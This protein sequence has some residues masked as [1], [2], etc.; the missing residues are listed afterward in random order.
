MG[1]ERGPLSLVSTIEELLEKNKYR[2]RS[3]NPRIRL[4][5]YVTLTT[6]HPLSKK[7]LTNFAD[8]RRS[9]CRYCSLVDPSHGVFLAKFHKPSDSV[10]HNRENPLDNTKLV[11]M[12]ERA[13]PTSLSLLRDPS[14][15]IEQGRFRLYITPSLR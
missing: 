9:F 8:K 3:R 11:L 12:R 13:L 7:V 2:L 1:L 4:E 6:W 5:G 14:W 10:K 15:N